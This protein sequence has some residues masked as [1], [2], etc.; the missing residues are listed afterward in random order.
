[1][2]IAYQDTTAPTTPTGLSLVSSGTLGS[3]AISWAPS[4]DPDDPV[5]VYHVYRNGNLVGSPTGTLFVDS[6]ATLPNSTVLADAF[7]R[8][9]NGWGSAPTGDSYAYNNDGSGFSTDGRDGL[10]QLTTGQTSLQAGPAATVSNV[11]AVTAFQ[12]SRRPKGGSIKVILVT[13][14][15]S[16]GTEA[17]AYRS[18]VDISQSGTISYGF[19]R[20]VSSNNV[21]LGPYAVAPFTFSP[22]GTYMMRTQ[23]TG[24]APTTLRIK[25]W[26]AGTVEPTSWGLVA[27]DSASA[28]QSAGQVGLRST[29]GTDTI[30]NLPLTTSFDSVNMT[31]LNPT[32]TYGYTVRAEDSHG[33]NSSQSSQLSVTLH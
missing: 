5:A 20:V 32:V 15:A 25:V 30:T 18:V 17:D 12:L 33:N 2:V 21:A 3:P 4:T 29:T 26:R 22:G 14:A 1:V 8:T 24:S 10:M 6:T 27:I 19:R 28:L 9:M 16:Q 31:D 13:R 11:D 23:V 7:S